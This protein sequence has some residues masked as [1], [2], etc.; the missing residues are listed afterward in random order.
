MDFYIYCQLGMVQSIRSFRYN[1]VNRII[2]YHPSSKKGLKGTSKPGELFANCFIVIILHILSCNSECS[3]IFVLQ[4]GQTILG[5]KTDRE[6]NLPGNMFP[7]SY[8][9]DIL[10]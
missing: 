2:E 10:L 8:K 5:F 3:E 6:S 1:M 4:I 9:M 7:M